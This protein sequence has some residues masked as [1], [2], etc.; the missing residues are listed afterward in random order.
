MG[1]GRAR[2]VSFS[3]EVPIQVRVPVD[4]PDDILCGVAR[5]LGSEEFGEDLVVLGQRVVEGIREAGVGLAAPQVSDLRRWIVVRLDPGDEPGRTEPLHRMLCNPEIVSTGRPGQMGE[6]RCLSFPGVKA[7][8]ERFGEIRVRWQEPADGAVREEVFVG[9]AARVVQH[10]VDH[11]DGRTVLH[12]V[13][14]ETRRA[15]L[16]EQDRRWRKNPASRAS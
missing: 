4:W 2:Q 15:W 6:E 9:F 13:D 12:R 10:E 1:R 16:Q 11:L 5:P 7:R 8:I 3:A 14:R